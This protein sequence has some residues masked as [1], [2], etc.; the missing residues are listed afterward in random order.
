MTAL[1]LLAPFDPAHPAALAPFCALVQET[2]LRMLWQGHS[3]AGDAWMNAA[4]LAGAG[5]TVP[6]G[7]GVQLTGYAHP[8]EAVVK[9]VS[10]TRQTGRPVV[11]G[12]GPGGRS[13]QAALHGAP[14]PSPLTHMRDYVSTMRTALGGTSG[15]EIGMGVLRPRMAFLC[16]ETADVAITWLT[17]PEYIRD[18]LLSALEEGAA[19]AW[20][21]R[22]R[23]VSVLPAAFGV[24]RRDGAAAIEATIGHHLTLPHYRD[25]LGR[26]GIRLPEPGAALSAEVCRDLEERG[27]V[28]TDPAAE[29][30][31]L[32][33]R[34][35]A[36]GVEE[37][38]LNVI[39]ATAVAGPRAVLDALITLLEPAEP[40]EGPSFRT[41]PRRSEDRAGV[42]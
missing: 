30:D 14:L 22:P 20:R 29:L 39:G 28:T 12:F 4:H 8:F 5:Y 34:Y 9:A 31:G 25:V 3:T 24:D 1:S 35:A 16:G 6:F 26:A 40:L 27:A 2:E 15:I 32:R 17:P 13:A 38:V 11:A 21:P 10:L 33:S 7:F 19:S 23:I 18:T 42:G 36:D 41:A 37:I